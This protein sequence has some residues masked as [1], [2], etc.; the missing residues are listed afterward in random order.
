[1]RSPMLRGL[2][3]GTGRLATGLDAMFETRPLFPFG[4]ELSPGMPAWYEHEG[5]E[6]YLSEALYANDGLLLIRGLHEI[7]IRPRLLLKL[8]RW[9][10][11]EVEDYR[12][13]LTAKSAVHQRF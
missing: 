1:M 9:F 7:A 10:G 11:P 2:V 6:E 4:A 3:K 8:S 12:K 5:V 13:T